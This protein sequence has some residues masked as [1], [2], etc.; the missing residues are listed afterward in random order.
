MGPMPVTWAELAMHFEQGRDSPR[1]IHYLQQAAENAARRYANRE[2]LA[3]LTRGLELLKTLPA[4]PE[5][6]QQELMLH[7][8]LGASLIAT[9]GYAAPEVEQTYT[10][11][12]HLCQY[13]ENPR[14]LFPVLRGLWVYYLT[15]AELQDGA[16]LGGAAPHPGAASA[17]LGHAP[18]GAPCLGGDLVV[19][20][21]GASALPHLEQG[22]TLYGPALPMY[23]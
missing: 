9:Q 4:T 17:R 21:R 22:M 7:L 5:R 23:I 6:S 18:G 19:P 11:A 1:A 12:R 13:L 15:R 3:H 20:G 2:A 8:A 10:R 16:H 14:Q